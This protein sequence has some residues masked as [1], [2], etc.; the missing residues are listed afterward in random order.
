MGVGVWDDEALQSS[1]LRPTVGAG[2]L[3][4]T[5]Y[6]CFLDGLCT[7]RESEGRAALGILKRVDYAWA[8]T[9]II[10]KTQLGAAWRKTGNTELV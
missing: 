9:L 7:K 6:C 10:T 1:R 4:S 8:T 5:C 2:F 3:L